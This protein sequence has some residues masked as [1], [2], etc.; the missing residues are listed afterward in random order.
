MSLIFK[1]LKLLLLKIIIL[2]YSFSSPFD[3]LVMCI[4]ELWNYAT[5]FGYLVIF[6]LSYFSISFSFFYFSVENVLFYFLQI[7]YCFL[8]HIW[9][10]DY[11]FK[12]IVVTLFYISIFLGGLFFVQYL[13]LCLHYPHVIAV[14]LLLFIWVLIIFI[15][16]SSF[17]WKCQHLC[18]SWVWCDSDA[19]FEL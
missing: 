9:S 2:F 17:F 1:V 18:H 6:V 7:T 15:I 12:S 16:L 14:C 8:T 10:T 5:D 19:S 11:S 13:S 4:L 3:I